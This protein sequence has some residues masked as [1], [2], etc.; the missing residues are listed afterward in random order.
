MKETHSVVVDVFGRNK[1]RHCNVLVAATQ[2][3]VASRDLCSVCGTSAES[4]SYMQVD[5]F[6][7]TKEWKKERK[8]GKNAGRQ[9][10]VWKRTKGD[11]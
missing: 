9:E 6:D 1:Q 2:R 10:E 11:R 4:H 8:K 7:H 5:S 3:L